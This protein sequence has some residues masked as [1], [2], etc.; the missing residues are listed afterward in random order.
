MLLLVVRFFVFVSPRL[1]RYISLLLLFSKNSKH[2]AKIYLLFSFFPVCPP[3]TLLPF[4]KANKS[5]TPIN[6][7]S[8]QDPSYNALQF[9][10]IPMVSYP[11]FLFSQFNFFPLLTFFE[12]LIQRKE[13]TFAF[14]KLVR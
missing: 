1:Y 3:Q 7:W 4:L 10:V 11:L 9:N 12:I 8:L 2:R 6:Q 5:P 14:V 13:Q